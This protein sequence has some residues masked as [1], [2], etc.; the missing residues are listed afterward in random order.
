M[1]HRST[2]RLSLHI[3]G[4]PTDLTKL[5]RLLRTE[6]RIQLH[7]SHR[8]E[9]LVEIRLREGSD[10]VA[11]VAERL[12]FQIL[13][14]L[15][16]QRAALVRHHAHQGVDVVDR[17]VQHIPVEE[18]VGSCAAA[19]NILQRRRRIDCSEASRRRVACAIKRGDRSRTLLSL[20]AEKRARVIERITY[21]PERMDDIA[22]LSFV[23][24][25]CLRQLRLDLLRIRYIERLRP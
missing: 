4:N 2:G 10:L 19:H 23:V 18:L 15:H 3:R 7:I 17:A 11:R 12:S 25:D 9:R 5:R 20:A 21:D 6:Q 22:V 1:V 16:L 13:K 24:S 14:R 8:F